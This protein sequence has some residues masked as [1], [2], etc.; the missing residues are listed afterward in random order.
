[1]NQRA[2]CVGL[3]SFNSKVIVWTQRKVN[4]HLYSTLPA[5]MQQSYDT[6]MQHTGTNA[7]SISY[8]F[9]NTLCPRKNGPLSMFKNLQN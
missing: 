5:H 3:R 4:A 1:M 2:I 6:Y 7:V 8:T 9:A